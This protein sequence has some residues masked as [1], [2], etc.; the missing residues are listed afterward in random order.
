MILWITVLIKQFC[1]RTAGSA[2]R[3]FEVWR[4]Q[5]SLDKIFFLWPGESIELGAVEA[6]NRIRSTQK[7][8]TRPQLL[9]PV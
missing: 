8:P 1:L 2:P 9:P 3:V 7:T 6:S 4:K 5:T